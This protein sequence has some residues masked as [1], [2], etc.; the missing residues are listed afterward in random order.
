MSEL[1]LPMLPNWLDADAAAL[2]GAVAPAAT[3]AAALP[4]LA[5]AQALT[6]QQRLQRMQ[7]SGLAECGAAGEPVHLAWR[8]FLRG[9]GPS[10]LVI[11]AT[12]FDARSLG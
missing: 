12:S 7:Q 6:P 9:H 1:R 3:L 11:D 8:R 4:G 2:S 10:V 5:R